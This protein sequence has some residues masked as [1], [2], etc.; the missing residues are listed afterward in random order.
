M[1]SDQVAVYMTQMQSH[2]D[3]DVEREL[4]RQGCRSGNFLRDTDVDNI[5]QDMDAD[6]VAV[7]I[8]DTDAELFRHRHRL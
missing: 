5:L 7:Y 3:A 1:D 2:L 4:L 8:Y 6:Q